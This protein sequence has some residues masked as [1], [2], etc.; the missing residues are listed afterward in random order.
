MSDSQRLLQRNKNVLADI[1]TK[2]Q[3]EQKKT[4]EFLKYSLSNRPHLDFMKNIPG[5]QG[6]LISINGDSLSSISGIYPS[7]L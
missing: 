3:Q 5:H 1:L 4:L 6:M 2:Q 7:Q